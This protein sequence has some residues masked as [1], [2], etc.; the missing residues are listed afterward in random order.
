MVVSVAIIIAAALFTF[1]IVVAAYLS[2]E[3]WS[4]LEANIVE[5]A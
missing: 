2:A 3:G 1:A 5:Q 4:T